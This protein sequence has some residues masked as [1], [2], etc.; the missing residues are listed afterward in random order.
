MEPWRKVRVD[1][2]IAVEVSEYGG[3]KPM[4]VLGVLREQE[5]DPGVT[6]H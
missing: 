6:F 2:I 1:D 4:R 5:E 3:L